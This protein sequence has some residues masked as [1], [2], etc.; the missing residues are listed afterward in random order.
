MAPDWREVISFSSLNK[1]VW[2]FSAQL[3][4]LAPPFSSFLTFSIVARSSNRGRIVVAPLFLAS[5]W[6]QRDTR[7]RY[8]APHHSFCTSMVVLNRGRIGVVSPLPLF[9]TS[10]TKWNSAT[11]LLY[12]APLKAFFH[13]YFRGRIVVAFTSSPPVFTELFRTKRNEHV[14]GLTELPR[15][16]VAP[17]RFGFVCFASLFARLP[18]LAF[19][20]FVLP[21]SS[22]EL[23]LGVTARREL[24]S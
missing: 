23:V 3:L 9:L 12:L 1:L 20:H 22:L 2:N 17:R 15:R 11:H 13:S 8:F 24:C 16:R 5:N 19:R 6:N 7:L 21:T 14:L 4:Y 18:S 10:P